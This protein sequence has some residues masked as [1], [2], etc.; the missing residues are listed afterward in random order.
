F[1][2]EMKNQYKNIKNLNKAWGTSFKKW[3]DIEP[4]T[5]GDTFFTSGEAYKTIYGKDFMKW[6]QGALEDHL[7]TISEQAH[8]Y[9]DRTFGVEVG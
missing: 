7:Q 8:K 6:Y 5:D 9:F 2:D 1:R 4:P 3:N